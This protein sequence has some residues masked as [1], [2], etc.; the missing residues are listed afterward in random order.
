MPA[1]LIKY[2]NYDSTI[3]SQVTPD[4]LLV[5]VSPEAE[6]CHLTEAC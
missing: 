1:V 2:R 5:S 6:V 4:N 3:V